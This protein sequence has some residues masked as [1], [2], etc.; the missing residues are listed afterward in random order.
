MDSAPSFDIPLETLKPGVHQ[1]DYQ[2][3]DAFFAAFDTDLLRRGKF[4]A[5]V[6]I[7]RV[8]SQFNLTVSFAGAAGVDCD[9][10]LEPFTLPLEGEEEV[11]IKYDS[12]DPREEDDVV[13]VP[14]GTEHYNVAR[15]LFETIGVSLPMSVVHDD[16]DL[17]CDPAMLAYLASADETPEQHP[18]AAIDGEIPAD[19]PWAALRG[20]KGQINPN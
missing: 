12:T 4:T 17:D 14:H 15:L 19:S 3:D 8:R 20:L 16:A 7:E 1:F 10:C 6:E 13:Y 18:S 5:Q 9:R 11:V 2:L